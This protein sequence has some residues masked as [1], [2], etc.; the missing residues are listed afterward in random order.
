MQSLSRLSY[1][2]T[3]LTRNKKLD[4]TA[5]LT[6]NDPS[7]PSLSIDTTVHVHRAPLA[8]IGQQL[9]TPSTTDLISQAF[10]PLSRGSSESIPPTTRAIGKP[11]TTR[12]SSYTGED[13]VYTAGGSSQS[14]A[15]RRASHDLSEIA[16]ICLPSGYLRHG[17]F[18]WLT[19]WLCPPG[20]VPPLWHLGDL[21]APLWWFPIGFFCPQSGPFSCPLPAVWL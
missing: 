20:E 18:T 15:Y 6:G 11:M 7:D 19:S 3:S 14:S 16:L 1:I 4:T 2:P 17:V 10:T 13:N 12:R 21:I 9:F 5:S 8:Q